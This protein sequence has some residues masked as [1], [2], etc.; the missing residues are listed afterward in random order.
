MW[1]CRSS[2][3]SAC[4]CLMLTLM[5]HVAGRAWSWQ[6]LLMWREWGWA[7]PLSRCDLW[8]CHAPSISL[9]EA[10][11]SRWRGTWRRG[12][13]CVKGCWLCGDGFAPPMQLCGWNVIDIVCLL[14]LSRLCCTIGIVCGLPVVGQNFLE[15]GPPWGTRWC[16]CGLF[17]S[18]PAS[19][20]LSILNEH[21]R[22]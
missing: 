16:C 10:F 19:S 22:L 14:V 5:P 4:V 7:R 15:N 17:W 21:F 3:C 11:Q 9:A 2:L 18:R 1:A 12:C 6:A 8:P 13:Q 20:P